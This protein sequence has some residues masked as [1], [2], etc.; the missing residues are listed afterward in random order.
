MAQLEMFGHEVISTPGSARRV[1][2]TPPEYTPFPDALCRRLEID[3][4]R[5][6][7][8]EWSPWPAERV[9]DEVEQFLGCV[10]RLPPDRRG[11]LA[12]RFKAELAR[13]GVQLG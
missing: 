2:W 7:S 3:L 1:V 12:Q 6:Q 11:D 8:A 9:R 10:D 13:L 4:R 5:L